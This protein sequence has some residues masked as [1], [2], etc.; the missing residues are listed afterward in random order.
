MTGHEGRAAD[1]AGRAREDGL[2][3]VLARRLEAHQPAVGPHDLERRAHLRRREPVPDVRQVL[4]ERRSDVR[5][6]QR[7]HGAL[8]LAELGE[9]LRGDRHRHIGRD[10]CR[11]LGDH[12]LVT[13]VRVGVQEADGQGLHAVRHKLLDGFAHGGLVDRLDDR[14]V[15]AG[16]LGH[17]ADVAGVGERLRLLVDHESE[18]RPRRPRLGEVEDVPE[19]TRDDQADEGPSPLEHRVR[20]DGRAVENRPELGKRDVRPCRCEPD[21]LDHPDRLVVGRAR[22][23]R[24]PDPLIGAVVENDVREGPADI[25]SDP[26]GHTLSLARRAASRYFSTLTSQLRA[27]PSKFSIRHWRAQ[28]SPIMALAASSHSWKVTVLRNF[29]TQS[30]PV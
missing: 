11:D 8:V 13:A 7:R 14:T 4:L 16:P 17:L 15:G 2:D 20:R 21:A 23:L 29:P 10:G 18:Q 28:I 5:V 24:E 19:P 9:D 22:R 3:R 30:P 25:D 6:H 1:S 26:V 27:W 12:P